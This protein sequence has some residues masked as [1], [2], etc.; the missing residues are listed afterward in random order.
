MGFGIMVANSAY[1]F[2]GGC[3]SC[4]N[5]LAERSAFLS[6]DEATFALALF[7]ELKGV[8]QDAALSYLKKYLRPVFK[9]ACK[10]IRHNSSETDRLKPANFAFA[11]AGADEFTPSTQAVR[12]R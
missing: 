7:C 6:Q 5:P 2:R 9:K 11:A 12:T 1:T 8:S 10:E 3:G 4:Y